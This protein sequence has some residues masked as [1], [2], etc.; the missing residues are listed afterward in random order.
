MPS[1]ALPLLLPAVDLSPV[2]AATEAAGHTLEQAL[3]PLF[4]YCERV[5]GRDDLTDYQFRHVATIRAA[6]D[7][8]AAYS[9]QVEQRHT[10]TCANVTGL[11]R[12]LHYAY[13]PKPQSLEKAMQVDWESIALSLL[14][15]LHPTGLPASPLVVRIKRHL[16]ELDRRTPPL[17][18]LAHAA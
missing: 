5:Q 3:L 10:A 15:R 2:E 11:N 6:L 9:T 8:V 1:P 16:A 14:E 12:Q 13:S 17:A 18:P 7:A 4:L